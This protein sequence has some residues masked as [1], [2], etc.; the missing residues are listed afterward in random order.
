MPLAYLGTSIEAA[1]QA[2]RDGLKKPVPVFTEDRKRAAK[3]PAILVVDPEHAGMAR[4]PGYRRAHWWTN[5]DIPPEAL[6][7]ELL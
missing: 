1:Q 4:A 2:A 5:G 3:S 6:T 7:I